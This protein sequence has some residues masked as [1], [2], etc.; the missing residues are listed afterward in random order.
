LAGKLIYARYPNYNLRTLN[1]LSINKDTS[2]LD[3][4]CGTG[5][6]VYSLRELGFKN[7]LGADPYIDSDIKY[8]NGVR[9]QKK[10]VREV[11]GKWDVVMLHHTFEHIENPLETL[12][13]IAK[14]LTSNGHCIIRIPIV[15]SYAWEHYGVNWVQLDAP[16]HL[17]L[18]SVKSMNI[19]TDQCGLKIQ[20]VVYDSTAFQF[21][22]S[23]QYVRDI[24]LKDKRSYSVNADT[25]IFTKKEILNFTKRAREL[26]LT[27]R[28]DQ[29]IF[30][31]SKS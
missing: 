7:L 18:H 9:I 1:A 14:L 11:D 20:N 5:K 29:A 16:R 10:T 30:Y 27:S 13:L 17:F 15:P 22:G 6:S 19:L 2:I 23:E 24:P 25:S 31:I 3:I 26:N 28:G 12:Q 8:N 4:G 21:W